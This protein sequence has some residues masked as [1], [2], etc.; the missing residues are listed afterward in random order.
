MQVKVKKVLRD[1]VHIP[2]KELKAA[3]PIIGDLRMGEFKSRRLGRAVIS[4][5]VY[6]TADIASK[7]AMEPLYDAQVT[8]IDGQIMRITGI[9]ESGDR[10]T[11][12]CW[13]VEIVP[14]SK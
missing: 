6:D 10:N 12:Q 2:T 11:Y 8:Y 9:E 1:G 13:D 3:A 7:E 5:I 14:C 4:A